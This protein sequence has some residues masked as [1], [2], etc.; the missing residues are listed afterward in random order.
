[1]KEILRLNYIDRCNDVIIATKIDFIDKLCVLLYS[2]VSFFKQGSTLVK[3]IEPK[4][5]SATEKVAARSAI[6]KEIKE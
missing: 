6:V 4:I 1:M 2:N 3:K 5:H